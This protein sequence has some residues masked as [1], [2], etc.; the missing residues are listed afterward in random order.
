M[1]FKKIGHRIVIVENQYKKIGHSIRLY[2]K[3]EE[4]FKIILTSKILKLKDTKSEKIK[5]KIKTGLF[6]YIS[7]YSD[8]F[9]KE[10]FAENNK[11]L[12][13]KTLRVKSN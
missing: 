9:K 8:E 2:F 7:T 6:K 4:G 10:I 11:F 12:K 5:Q 13:I 1:I 3:S